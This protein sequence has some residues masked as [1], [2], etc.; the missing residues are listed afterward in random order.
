MPDASSLLAPEEEE[1]KFVLETD[2][3]PEF[4]QFLNGLRGDDLLVE[5]I[6]NDLD[7]HSPATEI[8][9]EPDRL[10]CAGEG[11]PIDENGWARL[12]KMRGA[13]YT[14]PAKEGVFGIK[15]HGLKAC[16]T[17]GNDIVVRS[18]GKKIL[19]TLFSNGPDEPAYPGVRVPPAADP[20]GPVKGTTVEVPYRRLSFRVTQGEPFD[21]ALGFSPVQA[22]GR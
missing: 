10:V 22:A 3:A 2:E 11:D 4:W 13:G 17:L 7:A 19:Q 18:G 9:F 16:F 14:V 12:R 15:N 5:L 6:V 1:S 21:A 8:R 20:D